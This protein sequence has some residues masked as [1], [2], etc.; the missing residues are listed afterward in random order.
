MWETRMAHK[1]TL[2][3]RV[4]VLTE[5]IDNHLRE[6]ST[7][8]WKIER[9]LVEI[10]GRGLDHE[11]RISR[12]EG[13]QGVILKLVLAVMVSAGGLGGAGYGIFKMVNGG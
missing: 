5:R 9:H 13:R 8:L 3:E 1:I 6:V 7:G 10:N 2:T 11:K 12:V 4:G